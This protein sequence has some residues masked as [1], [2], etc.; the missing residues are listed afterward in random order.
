MKPNKF[1][2]PMNLEQEEAAYAEILARLDELEA[3]IRANMDIALANGM[4]REATEDQL[5]LNQIKRNRE[6]LR[7]PGE[8]R[9]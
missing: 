3:N 5:H 2:K 6:N 8:P 1:S 9:R 4:E 7:K